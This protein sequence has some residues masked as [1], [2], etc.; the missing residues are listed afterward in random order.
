[1]KQSELN[2]AI[3]K[4]TGESVAEI[5]H[6]GFVPL[7]PIPQERDPE[8]LILDWDRLDLERNVALVQPGT[9]PAFP[10]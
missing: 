6:R 9:C 2:R 1:M 4:A 3:S 7:T 8:D 5:S 10:S